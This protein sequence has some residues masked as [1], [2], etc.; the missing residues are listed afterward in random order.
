MKEKKFLT[1]ITENVSQWYLDVMELAQLAEYSPVKGTIVIRPNAYAIWEKVQDAF[2][3][4][5][6]EDGV[7]N[8]YFPLFIPYSLLQK[9]KD[10][11]KG[12]KPELAVVTHAGGEELEEPLVVRPT[13]ETIMYQM[14]SQWIHSYRDLPF[15]V[16]Q[17]CNVVRW[18][19]RTYPFLRGSEF[20]WQEGHTVHENEAGAEE[21]AL[22]ALAWYKKLYEEYYGVY[23]IDGIK[24]EAERFAG[25]LRTYTVELLMPDGKALQGGTSHNLGDN[26]AKAFN[27]QYLDNEDTLQYAW[28]T[29]WGLS[30]R[31]LGGLFMAHGDNNGLVLAPNIAP[32]KVAILPILSRQEE[33]NNKVESEAKSI[34]FALAEAKVSH[35]HDKSYDKTLGYR[36][37]EIEVQGIPLRIELG[38]NEVKENKI[39]I[40]RR[41]TL[42][43]ITVQKENLIKEVNELLSKIQINLYNKSKD[44]TLNKII[45]TTSYDEFKQIFKDKR[46]FVLAYWCEDPACEAK[47][48]EETKATTRVLSFEEM[49]RK[50]KGNCILCGKEAK[51]RWHFAQSY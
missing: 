20:L 44:N 51:H 19:K 11:V 47:I 36:R 18:E 6:K 50:E 12:F 30:T 37:N 10:H 9:E 31:S 25:A 17:W 7:R 32:T 45:F 24:S 46:Q 23:V 48:K 15:K 21:M 8:A 29:S 13:S 3:A 28:Q 22:K 38:I 39:T 42:E 26:F 43:K 4:M 5:I 34:A 41:D 35:I 14:F 40:V 2:N 49:E 27:I 16:N 33:D 1:P